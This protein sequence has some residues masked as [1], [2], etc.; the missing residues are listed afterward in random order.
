MSEQGPPECMSGEI[1][2][3]RSEKWCG[4]ERWPK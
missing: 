1:S 4:G 3:E 2:E